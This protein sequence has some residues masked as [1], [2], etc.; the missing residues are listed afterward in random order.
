MSDDESPTPINI[1]FHP[2]QVL[3]DE[4]LASLMGVSI[5]TV[6]RNRA[7]GDGPKLTQLSQRRHGTR[8]RDYQTW[9]DSKRKGQDAR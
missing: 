9:L 3:S 5:D 1:P 7:R 2:D 4:L 8:M 6:Q